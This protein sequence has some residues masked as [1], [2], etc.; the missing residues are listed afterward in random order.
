[1]PNLN[2]WNGQYWIHSSINISTYV[3]KCFKGVIG[4]VI[5]TPITPKS[6]M[7]LEEKYRRDTL[8]SICVTPGL[9]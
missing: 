4:F 6:T 8:S 9:I 7:L 2:W 3:S 5:K 1:M